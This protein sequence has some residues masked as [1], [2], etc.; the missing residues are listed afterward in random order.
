ML[1]CVP[2]ELTCSVVVP[3][4][5]RPQYLR[6]CLSALL[7]QELP[8]AEIVVVA[9]VD[10]PGTQ[11]V[12]AEVQRDTD[13]VSLATVDRPGVIAAMDTGVRQARADIVAFTDDDA[14]PR[15]DWLARL[16]AAFQED[17]WIAGVGGR[18]NVGDGAAGTGRRTV[19]HLGWFGRVIGNHHL[20][21]G[22]RR[23]V[24]VLK[25]VNCAYRRDVIEQQGFD[26]RLRGSGAQVHWELALGLAIIRRGRLL[27]YDPAILVDHEEAPRLNGRRLG[28]FDVEE[29]A[30]AD[31]AY[32]EA[33]LL[34]EHFSGLRRLV[35]LVWSSVVGHRASPGLVQAVRF[36]PKLRR[37][38][39]RRWSVARRA[40][41]EARRWAVTRPQVRVSAQ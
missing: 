10:D 4:Y 6:R 27:L 3:S 2:E 26:H 16:V 7:E 13:I 1:L 19:G 15:T 30:V 8:P 20:G 17:S 33:L 28:A 11:A 22:P 39:C 29:E 14:R 41:S 34:T 12:V 37:Q 5:H 18:D 24:A 31:A 25:G 40:R 35:Y 21:I 32:N 38:S 23:A 9:R 36:L